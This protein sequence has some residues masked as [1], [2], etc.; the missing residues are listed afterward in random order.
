MILTLE[1]I[2]T[3]TPE[4]FEVDLTRNNSQTVGGYSGMNTDADKVEIA[5][6]SISKAHCRFE[7]TSDGIYV[8]DLDSKYGTHYNGKKVSPESPEKIC[9]ANENPQNFQPTNITLGNS[10]FRLSLKQ[11][12]KQGLFNKLSPFNKPKYFQN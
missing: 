8:A 4:V 11:K 7:R 6:P 12:Q 9:N 3:S 2:G 5:Y 10:K 1:S